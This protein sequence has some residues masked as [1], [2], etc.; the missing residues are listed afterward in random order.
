MKHILTDKHFSPSDIFQYEK[1]FY[2]ASGAYSN[3]SKVMKYDPKDKS[4][5]LMDTNQDAFIEKFYKNGESEYIMTLID[6]NGVNEVCDINLQK[7]QSF[8]GK[9]NALDVTTLNNKV[10]IVGLD[11]N[12]LGNEE[13][14]TSIKMLNKELE[15]IKEV[16]LNI[17]PNYFTYT[18]PD[19]KLYLFMI[20]GDIVEIDSNLNTNTFPIDLSSISKNV[21][22]VLYNKNV[23]L[24]KNHILVNVEIHEPNKKVT[25][26]ANIS[27]EKDAPELELIESS[28][29][30]IILN[31]DNDSNEVYTRSYVENK[32]VINIRDINTLMVKNRIELKNDDAI[33]FVD[34]VKQ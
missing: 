24:D 23:M 4:L 26:L 25:A 13:N 12:A 32:T 17:I 28:Y 29:D 8:S 3:D 9:H 18:S 16:N 6:G 5:S 19:Q 2:F 31:V 1:N 30:E 15:L 11:T 7:C 34:N 33:Y 21:I 10:V 14:V 22:K 27:F 20:N